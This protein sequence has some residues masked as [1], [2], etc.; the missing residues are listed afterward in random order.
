MENSQ[1]LQLRLLGKNLPADSCAWKSIE[2]S[3]SGNVSVREE[4]S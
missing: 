3:F 2:L 4:N 1:K